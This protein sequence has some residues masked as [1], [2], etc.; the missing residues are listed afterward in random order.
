MTAKEILDLAQDIDT[1]INSKL[2]QIC[3][4]NDLAT[5]CTASYSDMPRNPNRGSSS[6]ADTVIKII[7]LEESINKD[8]DNLVDIKI[9]NNVMIASVENPEY[10]TLLELRYICFK[11]WEQIAVIMG[12][13]LRYIHKLHNY[14]LDCCVVPDGCKNLNK[15]D[16]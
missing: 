16:I 10:A 6:M 7:D 11:T 14:A 3:Y 1:R 5:K 13:T 12:Y 2:E 9:I 4:L 15:E 8:I